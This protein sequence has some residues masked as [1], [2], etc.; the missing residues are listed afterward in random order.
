MLLDRLRDDLTFHDGFDAEHLRKWAGHSIRRRPMAF[1]VS[2]GD[3]QIFNVFAQEMPD[4]G[5][6]ISFTDV[7]A[8]RETARA[9]YEMNEFL[10]RR[11][12]DRTQELGV[13]LA[14]AERA[15]ASKSRFVAAASHDLLQPLSAA[16]LF[17]SSLPDKVDNADALDAIAKTETALMGQN[18]LSKPCLIYHDLM[19]ARLSSMYK[20]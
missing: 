13:A 8:E 20:R 17:V 6:V 3:S 10:E 16:K 15:N 7:T 1:E 9:L 4:G 14:E 18:R 12:Q 11:V 5:F 19:R 2:R